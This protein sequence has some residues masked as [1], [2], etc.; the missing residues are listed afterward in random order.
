MTI[1]RLALITLVT[2]CPI[3]HAEAP[4]TVEL[5]PTCVA[6]D[7]A[8]TLSPAER[9][10]ATRALTRV[11]E[12]QDLLV[13]DTGC[14]D[15]YTLGHER[16]GD[17]LVIHVRGPHG[18]VRLRVVSP[19]LLEHAYRRAVRN[20]L[21]TAITV[22][23]QP[24]PAAPLDPYADVAGAPQ[25]AP[26]VAPPAFATVDTLAE[27]P[28]PRVRAR[29][30][31]WYA[32]LGVAPMVHADAATA[33]AFGYRY[34]RAGID[35]DAGLQLFTTGDGSQMSHG[36]RFGVRG[37]RLA[38]PANA[39]SFYVGG[40]LMLGSTQIDTQATSWSG[41]GAEAIG[42]VGVEMLR[43]QRG[44][45]LFAEVDVI[46]PLYELDN[47]MTGD[48]EWSPSVMFS[49]GLGLGR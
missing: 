8:D 44:T 48:A 2:L 18:A 25:P 19:A 34:E 32:M 3:A 31:L 10:D 17:G 5:A 30:G 23:T 26:A 40:G 47:V 29:G 36:N 46:A 49:I 12:E 41:G 15:T 7:P 27:Q 37:L 9:A 45:H 21:D 33:V 14:R 42:T 35:F 20:L 4:R 13:V 22:T 6:I 38:T 28:A 16:A 39:N 1:A 43:D 11:L 24:Q